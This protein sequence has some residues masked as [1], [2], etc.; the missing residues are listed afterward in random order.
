MSTFLRQMFVKDSVVNRRASEL[1]HT[2]RFGARALLV[3]SLVALSLVTLGWGGLV[4]PDLRMVMPY[5]FVT[6]MFVAPAL[7]VV[8]VMDIRRSGWTWSRSA[9]LACSI[10]AVALL[11][12]AA[13][14]IL[15]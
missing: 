13:Y 6:V 15:A 4:W 7:I 2:T 3:G 11:A 10:A 9:A 14:E 8:V 12:A 5:A 1:L